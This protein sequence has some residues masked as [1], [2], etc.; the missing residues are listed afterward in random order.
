[1][2]QE[3]ANLIGSVVAVITL[4]IAVV[5]FLRRPPRKRLQYYLPPP[6]PFVPDVP[7]GVVARAA[8]PSRTTNVRVANTGRVS[9]PTD[10][11]DAPLEIRLPGSSIISAVQTGA[12]PV[13]LE[14][15]VAVDGDRVRI[16]PFLFNS[17][18]LV[19]LTI[20]A[21]RPSKVR[22]TARITDIAKVGRRRYVY[23]PGTG[24]DGTFTRGDVIMSFVVFPVMFVLLGTLVFVNADAA[25]QILTIWVFG[26]ISV[27]Y[28]SFL[29][30]AVRRS[31][32]WRTD[33][34]D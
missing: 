11:W 27:V 14:V 25:T 4:A 9:L 13:G 8:H 34:D 32:V 2:D 6:H 21:D 22:V 24:V 10:D 17:S 3:T 20:V 33:L 19:E 16:E 31:R 5:T 15:S 30:R 1:M 29:W 26:G 12:R 7:A 28:A 18:D 23:P